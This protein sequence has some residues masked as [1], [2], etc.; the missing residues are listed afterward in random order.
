M[1]KIR[2]IGLLLALGVSLVGSSLSAGERDS[3]FFAQ[4]PVLAWH[5]QHFNVMTIDSLDQYESFRSI[6]ESRTQAHPDQVAALQNAIR[7]NKALAAALRAR[8]VQINNI[9]AMQQALNGTL[10]FYLR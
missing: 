5:G 8:N 10:V 3:G 6:L 4:A 1:A 2:T 7:T 9:V